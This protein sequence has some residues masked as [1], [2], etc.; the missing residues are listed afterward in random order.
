MYTRAEIYEGPNKHGEY[1]YALFW[2]TTYHPGHPDGEYVLRE[3]G[4][5]F[6]AQFPNWAKSLPTL[7]KRRG[8]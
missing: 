1:H 8:T 4:Q 6:L 2:M 7:D 3:R 5:H